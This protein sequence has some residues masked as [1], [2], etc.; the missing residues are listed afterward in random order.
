MIALKMTLAIV[1]ILL[2]LGGAVLALS[3]AWQ[4]A[5]SAYHYGDGY[6]ACGQF[7]VFAGSCLWSLACLAEWM[8]GQ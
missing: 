2:T 3:V 8:A 1:L 7:L 5:V 4:A 6:L